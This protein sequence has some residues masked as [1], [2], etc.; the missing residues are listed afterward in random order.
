MHE[1]HPEAKQLGPCVLDKAKK[2]ISLFFNTNQ[3]GAFAGPQLPVRGLKTFERRPKKEAAPFREP[4]R[5]PLQCRRPQCP[6][7]SWSPRH[8]NCVSTM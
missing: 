8:H 2:D 7:T 3:C 5:W 4:R 6:R 1:T